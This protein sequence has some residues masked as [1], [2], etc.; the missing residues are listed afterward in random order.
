MQV[1]TK[2][3][4]KKFTYGHQFEPEKASLSEYLQLC[5]DNAP[6]RDKL[7]ADILQKFFSE[8]SSTT[9]KEI[10]NDN[11]KKLAMNCFLSLRAYKLIDDTDEVNR[12]YELTDIGKKL[13]S[14][15]TD[16]KKMYL[17]FA[18]HI[19][20]N[21]SGTDLLKAIES[22]NTRGEL[23]TLQNIIAELNEM[24]YLLS[25]N[26]IY[27]STMRQ[28]LNKAGLFQSKG[29]ISWDVFND[30]TGISFEL[31]ERAYDLTP[32]Q[33]Y[34]L[35]SMLDLAITDYTEWSKILEHTASIRKFNYD[36]KMFPK[37]VLEPL[38]N[39]ELIEMEK[40]TDGRG[41]KPN[42]IK[43]TAKAEKEIL[44]PFIKNIA[45]L[46]K[47]GDI[48]LNKSLDQVITDISSPDIHIKGKALELLAIW[49][50]RLCSLRFTAWRKRDIDTGKGEVDVMAA[51]DNFVY[52]K[53][54]IQCKNTEKVDIDV[55][56]KELG[57][58][59]VTNA[60]VILIVTTGEF[61][62][63]ARVYADRVSTISRY[64]VIL[65]DKND[66]ASLVM[67]KISII[68]ILDSIAKRTFA[69]REYGLT[70]KEFEE[71]TIE[72]YKI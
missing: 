63:D 4:L 17:E 58:T 24:G 43:L 27:P 3:N 65:L 11:Q 66:V 38:I 1:K 60:D 59:F 31:L 20:L 32:E 13:L 19:L 48:E 6:S 62:N 46:T 26:V 35:L 55:V 10:T 22:I 14:L 45:D 54:Q 53:W 40:S 15:K 33:K 12:K 9:E 56:A 7:E 47:V 8:H 21:L 25:K 16:E 50:V 52:S 41:A 44:T 29:I 68:P 23:P 42:K 30:I 70:N 34:F 28:W 39:L 18:K 49:M 64:Y 36:M 2:Q 51:S 72:E 5:V 71:L 37:S 69:R 67:D 61:S 57:M